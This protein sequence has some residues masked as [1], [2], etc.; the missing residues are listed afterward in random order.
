MI[1]VGGEL[2]MKGEVKF[3]NTMKNFGFIKPDEG[4]EDLFVHRSDID[5]NYLNEGDMVE[6]E[7]EQSDRGPR[8]INVKKID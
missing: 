5:D 4:D 8:A 6:F 1:N 7:T 2:D 3:Y